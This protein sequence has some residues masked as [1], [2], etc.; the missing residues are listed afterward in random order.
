M[1]IYKLVYKHLQ[2]RCIIF[3]NIYNF[4]RNFCIILLIIYNSLD[5]FL[6]YL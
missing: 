4:F 3:I 5:Y 1:K 2:K 6:N